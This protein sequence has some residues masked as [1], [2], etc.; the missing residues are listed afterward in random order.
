MRN[1][2]KHLCGIIIP[3]S[4]NIGWTSTK[5]TKQRAL[6]CL[7]LSNFYNCQFRGNKL[8]RYIE[9]WLENNWS[10]CCWKYT[11]KYKSHFKVG[12]SKPWLVKTLPHME[13]LQGCM[14]EEILD[15]EYVHLVHGFMS[16]GIGTKCP[17][18]PRK[19][20]PSKQIMSS[21]LCVEITIHLGSFLVEGRWLNSLSR[22][23]CNILYFDRNI[24]LTIIW[25]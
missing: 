6:T 1:R 3:A 24:W 2:F 4:Q 17:S 22:V 10:R 7:S 25:Y 8:H 9:E 13:I 14:L 21:C 19:N 18:S 15:L 23:A 5:H 16:D 20:T 12:E 11:A